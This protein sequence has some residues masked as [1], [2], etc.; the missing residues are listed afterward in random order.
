MMEVSEGVIRSF[1]QFM[2]R[3]RRDFEH[4]VEALLDVRAHH[5]VFHSVA[6][7][8]RMLMRREQNY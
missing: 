8:Q 5:L 7:K 1:D 6:V 3:E 2:R 4:G